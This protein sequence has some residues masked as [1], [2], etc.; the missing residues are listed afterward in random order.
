ME[1]VQAM[2]WKCYDC[3]MTFTNPGQL[4]R[5]KARFCVGG[6]LGD[7]EALMMKKGM[8]S[9]AKKPAADIQFDE[10]EPSRYNPAADPKVQQLAQT[11]GKSMEKIHTRN[12]D[13]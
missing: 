3:N 8:R 12:R 2:N 11:H 4:Q 13:L 7:P 5:H 6:A 9:D 10:E 1:D